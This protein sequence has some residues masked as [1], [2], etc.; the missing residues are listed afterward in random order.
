MAEETEGSEPRLDKETVK[1]ALM[2]ILS[3]FPAFR[4]AMATGSKSAASRGD[5]GP[6]DAGTSEA[7][8]ETGHSK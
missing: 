5:S 8:V 4:A 7:S 1:E 2:D 6:M 3:E